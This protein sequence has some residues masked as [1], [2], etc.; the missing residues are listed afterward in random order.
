MSA[1]ITNSAS[2]YTKESPL[3]DDS[4]KPTTDRPAPAMTDAQREIN[5]D[6]PDTRTE[7]EKAADR[8]YEERIEDEY[9][10]REGGA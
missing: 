4:P 7:A 10:K 5:T 1:N 6:K 9:A 2:V 3:S 8:M